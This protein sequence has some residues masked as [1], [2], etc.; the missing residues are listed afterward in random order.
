MISGEFLAVSFFVSSLFRGMILL[1]AGGLW[2]LPG[3]VSDWECREA[4]A[5]F[6]P[7]FQ[8]TDIAARMSEAF[9][10]A[11]CALH[12][13]YLAPGEPDT[14]MVEGLRRAIRLVQPDLV[15]AIGGGSAMDAA[16]VA[17]STAHRPEDVAALAG[18]ETDFGIPA[19]R[20]IC[21]QT[22]AGTASEVSRMAVISQKGAGVKLRY[23]PAHMGAD[24]ALLD[25]QLLVSLATWATAETGAD[26]L[27]HAIESYLSQKSNAISGALALRAVAM[28]WQA[29]P[30]AVS[31]P[32][33]LVAR[34]ACLVASMMAG[35]AFNDT[36]LGL[37]HAIS[38]AL[39]AQFHLRHGLANAVVL[40]EVLAFNQTHLPAEKHAALA[41]IMGGS[42]LA[43]MVGDFLFGLGLTK[44]LEQHCP[45][46]D[47][48]ALAPAVMASGNIVTNPRRVSTPE[49]AL[50]LGAAM[51]RDHAG[52]RV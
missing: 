49:V 16:K 26:A 44:N 15:I 20:L 33:D 1:E 32:D 38:A 34:E 7:H 19:S 21:V 5:V 52:R 3:L 37:V 46:L 12:V 10:K 45:T 23:R 4:V 29:L 35:L 50:V 22:T 14:D 18:F 27:T 11:G 42:D 8:T 48:V 25:P 24:M 17:R 51:A 2:N 43:A 39:G 30:H 9:G 6:D 13:E 47:P 40:P 31:V 28:L 41:A 36:E